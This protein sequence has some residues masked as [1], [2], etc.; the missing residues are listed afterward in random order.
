MKHYYFYKTI[1][2]ICLHCLNRSYVSEAVK[3]L[4]EL[5][6]RGTSL[7]MIVKNLMGLMG[8]YFGHIKVCYFYYK[9]LHLFASSQNLVK[10]AI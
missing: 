4:F 3:H 1:L 8:K 10:P 9:L 7:V 6:W 2:L 5:F